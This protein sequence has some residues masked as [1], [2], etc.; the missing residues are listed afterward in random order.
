V[1]EERSV[2]HRSQ[3]VNIQH[4]EYLQSENLLCGGKPED[5]CA[6]HVKRY[7]IKSESKLMQA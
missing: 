3:I 5:K 2:P 4:D 6:S 1:I 7:D